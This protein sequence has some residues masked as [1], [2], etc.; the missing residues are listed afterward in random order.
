MEIC[1]S[2]V[3]AEEFMGAIA[4]V[5]MA[6]LLAQLPERQRRRTQNAYIKHFNEGCDKYNACEQF[7][8]AGIDMAR[9]MV[10]SDAAAVLTDLSR[11]TK[12]LQKQ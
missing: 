12:D 11:K 9:L 1:I 6:R 7:C 8:P 2:F 3:P 10:H 4:M 5:S